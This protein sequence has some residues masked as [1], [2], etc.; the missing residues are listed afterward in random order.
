M[1]EF[2]L[3]KYKQ[4]EILLSGGIF[5]YSTMLAENLVDNC[6]PVQQ[7]PTQDL[8]SIQQKEVDG[9]DNNESTELNAGK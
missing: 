3:F 1:F 8:P 6:K 5:R 7:Y 4:S 2:L 9:N